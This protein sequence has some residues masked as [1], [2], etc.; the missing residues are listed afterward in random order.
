MDGHIAS[1]VRRSLV[2]NW[3]LD[4]A[5]SR[6]FVC[7][8]SLEYLLLAEAPAEKSAVSRCQAVKIGKAYCDSDAKTGDVRDD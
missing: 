7:V 8:A 1:D 6:V 5:S 3:K 4:A 2:H